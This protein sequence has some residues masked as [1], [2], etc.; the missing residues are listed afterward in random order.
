[1]GHCFD[2]DLVAFVAEHFQKSEI[3]VVLFE[4]KIVERRYILFSPEHRHQ[5]QLGLY[6]GAVYRW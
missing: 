2:E 3:A 6:S 1:V 4:D 5:L